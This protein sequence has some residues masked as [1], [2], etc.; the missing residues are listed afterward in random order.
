LSIEEAF[1]KVAPVKN[2]TL[3]KLPNYRKSNPLDKWII[4]ELNKLI[5]DVRTGF[6]TYRLNNAT[7]PILRFL[8]SLT[9]WYIRRSRKRFWKSESDHDKLEAYNTLNDV[10]VEFSKI[11]SP[12]MPFI[13]EFI[14]KELTNKESVHLDLYPESNP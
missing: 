10:L 3:Y 4:S 11:I 12:F 9:N 5:A 7:R 6:D 2:S 1:Y 8:D 13:S 14:Y